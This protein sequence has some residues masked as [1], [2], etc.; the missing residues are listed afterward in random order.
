MWFPSKLNSAET[1]QGAIGSVQTTT[2]WSKTHGS[3]FASPAGDLHLVYDQFAF[4][5]ILGSKFPV[6]N[7]PSTISDCPAGYIDNRTT[8]ESSPPWSLFYVC[9]FGSYSG[10]NFLGQSESGWIWVYTGAYQNASDEYD[11]RDNVPSHIHIEQA[12]TTKTEADT[13]LEISLPFILVVTVFNILKIYAMYC[14]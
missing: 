10:N 14:A 12:Y 3:T 2:T 1:R 11:V 4:S 6:P 8:L 9:N 5:A 7:P 13:N